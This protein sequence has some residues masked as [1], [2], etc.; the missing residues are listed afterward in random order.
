MA[1]L[2]ESATAR[3]YYMQRDR[4]LSTL[5]LL[6]VATVTA[7]GQARANPERSCE[8]TIELDPPAGRLTGVAVLTIPDA[9]R[10][11]TATG[12]LPIA[13]DPRLEL[14]SASIDEAPI[15][16]ERGGKDEAS[17]HAM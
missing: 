16:I 17:G 8:L 3:R 14:A 7:N 10:F 9:T 2:A 5:A 12:G 13:L 11:L 15:A 6:I 1:A 4:M